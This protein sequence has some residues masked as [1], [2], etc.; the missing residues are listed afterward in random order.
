M[1][2]MRENQKDQ[3]LLAALG[4]DPSVSINVRQWPARC[5]WYNHDGSVIGPMPCDPYSRQRYMA[6]GLRP[7]VIGLPMEPMTWPRVEVVPVTL[8]D[9]V[10]TLMQGRETWKV[11]AT[12]LLDHLRELP[13]ETIPDELPVDATR[14]AKTLD[15]IEE[16]LIEEKGIWCQ[17]KRLTK[18][19]YLIFHRSVSQGN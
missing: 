13:E 12:E 14:L 1:P 17:R 5:V 8:A 3:E 15:E 6:R 7:E 19:R 10:D 9:G 4:V 16:P 11:T 18:G 2:T